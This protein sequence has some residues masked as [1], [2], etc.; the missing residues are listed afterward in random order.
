[1]PAPTVALHGMMQQKKSC[2]DG[3]PLCER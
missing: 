2:S 1:V 3:G